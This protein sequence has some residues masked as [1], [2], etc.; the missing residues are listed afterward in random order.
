M[1]NIFVIGDI[2]LDINFFAKVTRNAPEKETMPIYNIS[3]IN[4]ILGGSANVANNLKQLDAD[5]TLIGIIGSDHSGNIVT[6]ELIKQNITHKLFVD[7]T[8]QTT[9]KHRIYR[10]DNTNNNNKEYDYDLQVRYDTED[11]H[12]IDNTL[13]NKIMDYVIVE[14]KNNKKIDAIILS[15]YDKGTLTKQLC[16][17]IIQYSNSNGIPTFVDPKIKNYMKYIGCFLFKPNQNE[18]EVLTSKTNLPNIMESLKSLI[19]CDHILLTRGKEGMILDNLQ[20]RIEHEEIIH[21]VDVTGAGDIVM[22]ILVYCYLKYNDLMISARISNYIAGKS[23]GFVGN[24]STSVDDIS[25]YLTK[26]YRDPASFLQN[27]PVG[28]KI[29]YDYEIDRLYE[30]ST[31]E[32]RIVFTNG[33]FDI[34]HSAHIKLLQY[35]KSIGEILVVGL[36][37]DESIKRLK[38]QERPINYIDERST[39][40]SCF[41]FVDY[42]IIF[43]NDTPYEILKYI[44][45]NVIVKG[46]DYKVENII[47][48]EFSEE[49]IL[50]NFIQGKSSTRV[51]NK[52]KNI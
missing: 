3:T 10:T 16:Q 7:H 22:A 36:N 50:F 2:I 11:N 14:N 33:C 24:Y 31:M 8:R 32:K 46:G 20:N 37:S 5:I 4:Y 39:I 25:E 6:Q 28:P 51:I 44:K 17:D 21:V 13:S 49:V 23:V 34:I 15:D 47:G 30:F 1:P 45:P 12:D 42:I 27:P 41:D 18:S 19:Q 48:S 43:N 9:T 29:I 52:I 40:L 26:F 38:G 35:A